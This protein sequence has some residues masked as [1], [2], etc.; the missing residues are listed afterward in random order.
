MSWNDSHVPAYSIANE[1]FHQSL[2]CYCITL[3]RL[4]FLKESPRKN[5]MNKFEV[6]D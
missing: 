5:Y 1:L 2:L 6:A 4:E 3:R